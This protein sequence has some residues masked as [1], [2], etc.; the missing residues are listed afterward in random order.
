[1]KTARL[2]MIACC[3]AGAF[4]VSIEPLSPP[5]LIGELPD[6]TGLLGETPPGAALRPVGVRC[7]RVDKQSCKILLDNM[8][9]AL[10]QLRASGRLNEAQTQAQAI[11][12]L[13]G[14]CSRFA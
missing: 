11:E 8:Q 10:E 12:C 7:L 5:G 13:N 4:F 9:R 14:I 3:F 2:L 1:M 6:L